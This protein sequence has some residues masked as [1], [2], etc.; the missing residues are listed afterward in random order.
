VSCV[1][2]LVATGVLAPERRAFTDVSAWAAVHGLAVLLLDGP[3]AELGPD[4]QQAAVD[5]LL[6]L[7]DTGLR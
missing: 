4:E 5:R 7:V 6:D 1:D 3:L 2:E